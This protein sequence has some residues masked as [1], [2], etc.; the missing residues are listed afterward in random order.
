[1]FC[2]EFENVTEFRTSS[3]LLFCH[4]RAKEMENAHRKKRDIDTLFPS[5][6]KEEL[7]KWKMKPEIRKIQSSFFSCHGR[8]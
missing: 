2:G 7:R 4:G 8:V 1:M 3:F 5:L 6:V